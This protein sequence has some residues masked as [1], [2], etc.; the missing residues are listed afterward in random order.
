MYTV[1]S[2]FISASWLALLSLAS[3]NM[4]HA[5]G[6][7]IKCFP[8]QL[9]FGGKIN[10][11]SFGPVNGRCPYGTEPLSGQN[12]C[13]SFFRI[14]VTNSKIC[15]PYGGNPGDLICGELGDSGT[16]FHLE[17]V[18]GYNEYF[19]LSKTNQRYSYT[20]K[21]NGQNIDYSGVCPYSSARA[22]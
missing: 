16:D 2:C 22:F 5:K 1:R 21:L 11:G 17:K 19:M 13:V 15:F 18:T 3:P 14:D 4:A 7:V 10:N 9:N 20:I 6:W 8:N 12:V